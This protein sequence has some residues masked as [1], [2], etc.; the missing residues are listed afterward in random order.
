MAWFAILNG[1]Y[2][3]IIN[4]DNSIFCTNKVWI[5]LAARML[6]LNNMKEA[7]ATGDCV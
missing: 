3:S 7:I 4:N 5:G 6:L 1:G 2:N